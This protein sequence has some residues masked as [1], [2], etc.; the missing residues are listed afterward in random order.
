MKKSHA[1]L[2]AISAAACGQAEDATPVPATETAIS[3]RALG[4]GDDCEPDPWSPVTPICNWDVGYGE[5]GSHGVYRWAGGFCC[6]FEQECASG[7]TS[8]NVDTL[9]SPPYEKARYGDF[10]CWNNWPDVVCWEHPPIEGYI[11][12]REC[13][14]RPDGSEVNYGCG[15]P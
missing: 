2:F 8:H 6:L 3:T 7:L 11:N 14:T 5:M 10:S 13:Y 4:P 12:I 1:F 9:S 15:C